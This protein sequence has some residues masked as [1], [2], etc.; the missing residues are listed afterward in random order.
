M[1]LPKL[2]GEMAGYI[3]R[4]ESAMQASGGKEY[5][6][7]VQKECGQHSHWQELTG[8]LGILF[9]VGKSGPGK[10]SDL[11]EVTQ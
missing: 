9:I 2:R 1:R 5:P 4:G 6:S 8:I 7:P 11:Y 10:T 3:L